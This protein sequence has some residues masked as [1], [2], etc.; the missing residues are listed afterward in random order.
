MSLEPKPLADAIAKLQTAFAAEGVAVKTIIL[1]ERGYHKLVG[2]LT[3]PP[4]SDAT[5]Q[6]MFMTGAGTVLIQWEK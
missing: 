4:G 6:L 1:D 5:G 2:N 3:L